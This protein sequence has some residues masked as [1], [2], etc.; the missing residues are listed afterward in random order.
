MLNNALG[1]INAFG[2]A[3]LVDEGRLLDVL[4]A[5]LESLREFDRPG[6]AILDP[7]L[8]SDTV[9]CKAN[10]LTRFR[11]LDELDAPS[12]DEQSVYAD[13]RNPLVDR[14]ASAAADESSSSG[15]SEVTR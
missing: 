15:T 6:T 12:L 14:P 4:R 5:E 7:L 1:V 8:E 13:V 3:G 9:P 2:T 11:G 10:L